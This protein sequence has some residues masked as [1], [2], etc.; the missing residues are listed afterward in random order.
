MIRLCEINMDS[1]VNWLYYDSEIIEIVFLKDVY[2][3][4]NF[5]I[6]FIIRSI[7]I[8]NDIVNK[9]TNVNCTHKF[10]QDE[11]HDSQKV[12]KLGLSR[13]VILINAFDHVFWILRIYQ[14]WNVQS[15]KKKYVIN[16]MTV[17]FS[18]VLLSLTINLK[19]RKSVWLIICWECLSLIS[20]WFQ[21]K[22]KSSLTITCNVSADHLQEEFNIE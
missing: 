19:D 21:Q 20:D 9:I 17:D 18:R 1:A 22:Q 10:S 3:S 14:F 4:M 13:R 5:N 8:W 2:I 15:M 11:W 16:Q 12:M 6:V 7:L